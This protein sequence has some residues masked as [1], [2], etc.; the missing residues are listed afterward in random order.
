VANVQSGV[1]E[2]NGGRLRY[3]IAG[4]GPGILLVHGGLA[5]RHLWDDQFEALAE[6]YRVARY[7]QR[8]FGESSPAGGEISWFEDI[9]GMLDALGMEEAAI[10]G[11]S[12]GGRAALDFAIAHPERVR[13]LVLS[14]PGMSGNQFSAET[15]SRIE[16]ADELLESGNI[17]GG[18]EL[19][20]RLWIDGEGRDPGDVPNGARERTRA[21][22]V[23]NYERDA[24][25]DTSP[26][27]VRELD[28]PAAGRLYELRVP[29]LVIVGDRD[30]PDMHEIADRLVQSAPSARKAVIANAAHHPNLE[31]PDEFNRLVLD[32][33]LTAAAARS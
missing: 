11:L 18:V 4:E 26:V 15:G 29:T 5:D 33:L 22:M 24:Q 12:M 3:D 17:P 19:E 7:D 10:V 16:E 30:I 14:G 27:S 20:L 2:V 13:A 31:H 1:V 23:R 32:F 28:P 6:H 21:M 25:L 8:G 9:G